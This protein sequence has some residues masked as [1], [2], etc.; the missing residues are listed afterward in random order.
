MARILLIG[1]YRP[2]LT[3]ARVLHRAGHQVWAGENGY[4]DYLSWSQSVTG[5]LRIADFDAGAAVVEDVAGHVRTHGF[6]AVW[7][8]SDRATRLLAEHR[9][10]LPEDCAVVSPEPDRVSQVVSKT[11]MAALC[12]QVNVPVAPYAEVAALDALEA[13]CRALGPPVVVKPTGEGAL[14]NA[15][16]VITLHRASDLE[17]ELPRWPAGHG[18]LL[19]QKRL[20][21]PRHNHYFVADRGR[22]V[23]AAALEIIRTDRADGSGYAVEGVSAPPRPDLARQTATLVEALNYTGAGCVQ[24]MTSRQGDAT[25]FLEIN[26][27]FGANF[28]GA[29]AAGADMVRA[30]LDIAAGRPPQIG[31]DPWAKTRPG[32]RYVWT[33][34]DLSGWL[35]RMRAGAPLSA[36]IR[37]AGRLMAAAMGAHTHLVFDWRDPMPALGCALHP[38]L[39][40]IA[41]RAPEPRPRARPARG[42][43]PAP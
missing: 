31:P 18:E 16:K 6:D 33:K 36:S 14:I 42:A 38:L 39:R 27:R 15:K 17:A 13:A 32:V 35:W 20:D 4:C 25:S 28:A 30:A 10:H 21:G 24:Y 37:D 40:R 5:T 7:P 34:G 29:E 9:A 11:A 1:N 12:A 8:V 2:S 19:V 23:S 3:I 43:P 22:L 26:P 41:R